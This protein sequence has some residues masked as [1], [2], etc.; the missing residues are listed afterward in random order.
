LLLPSQ[1]VRGDCLS[2]AARKTRRPFTVAAP[3]PL[4][5]TGAGSPARSSFQTPEPTERRC[6][7]PDSFVS[8]PAARISSRTNP[9]PP[10]VFP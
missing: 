8:S 10:D 9:R 7:L 6:S 2:A 1:S 4:R 3:F 5:Q